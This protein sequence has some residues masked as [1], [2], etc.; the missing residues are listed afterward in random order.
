MLGWTR[1]KLRTPEATDRWTW[2]VN[3]IVAHAQLRLARPLVADLRRLW[4]KPAEPGRLTPA[5][6]RRGFRNL[7]PGLP[8]PARAPKPNRPGPGRPPSSKNRHPATR[9][10][11]LRATRKG[12]SFWS[13]PQ[14]RTPVAGQ[15]G[16]LRPRLRAP[17]THRHHRTGGQASAPA[18][19]RPLAVLDL[20]AVLDGP[21]VEMPEWLA[22]GLAQRC[23]GVLHADG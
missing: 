18:V 9:K 12:G 2:L 19:V 4:E 22:Q 23:E 6:V 7:R 11:W 20:F 16:P 8:C 5:R 14:T 21:V 1:R 10:E 17:P 15:L 13:V 3:V